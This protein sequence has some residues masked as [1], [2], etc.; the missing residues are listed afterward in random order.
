LVEGSVQG[1]E[2]SVEQVKGIM[3]EASKAGNFTTE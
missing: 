1:L 3:E 2:K